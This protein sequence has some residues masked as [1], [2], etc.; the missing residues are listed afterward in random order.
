M[1]DFFSLALQPPWALSSSFS[2]M[3]IF[4]DGRTPW[5]SDQLVARPLPK[6]RRAQT[7]NK[8]IHT[9]N[10]HALSGIRTHDASVRASEDNSCLRLLGCCDRHMWDIGLQISTLIKCLKLGLYKTVFF[11]W[12][13]KKVWWCVLYCRWIVL[14]VRVINKYVTSPSWILCV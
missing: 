13:W 5:T 12:S 6:H 7:Q 10:I 1:R 4:T 11:S 3:I 14:D 8:H 2:F 9:P